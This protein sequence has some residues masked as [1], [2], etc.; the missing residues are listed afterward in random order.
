MAK[1]VAIEELAD[2]IRIQDLIHGYN[3]CIDSEAYEQIPGFFVRDGIFEGLTGR[4]NISNDLEAFVEGIRTMRANGFA[5]MRHFTTNLCVQILGDR[6]MADSF[7]LVTSIGSDG[8]G[9]IA[10]TGTF[11]DKLLR[12]PEGWLFEER[13]A[14][15][16]GR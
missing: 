16:D 4:V 7:M 15:V 5:H 10:A 9:R 3:T 8:A 11:S 12:T 1:D 13:I 14:T 6:A 2:R